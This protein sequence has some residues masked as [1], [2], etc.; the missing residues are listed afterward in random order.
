MENMFSSVTTQVIDLNCSYEKAWA[1]LSDPLFQ[2]QWGASFFEDI[3][4]EESRFT[5][6]TRFGKMDMKVVSD[7]ASGIIDTYMNGMLTNPTRLM[8]LGEDAC[9][10]SFTLFK[11]AVATNEMF[12]SMG[13]SN[14]KKDLKTLKQILEDLNR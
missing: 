8:R 14:L 11:P 2:K 1:L 12:Q 7:K 4:S 10:Y 5:A 3:R 6:E 9:V 13:I